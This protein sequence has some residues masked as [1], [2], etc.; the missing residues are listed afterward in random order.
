MFVCHFKLYIKVKS[1]VLFCFFSQ[2]LLNFLITRISIL[3][4][5][6]RMKG[7]PTNMYQW[8][9]K[10]VK[11]L[12]QMWMS[13][14]RTSGKYRST[15]HTTFF[16]ILLKRFYKNSH[17]SLS[18]LWWVFYQKLQQKTTITI[19]H[20]KNTNMYWRAAHLYRLL[21][22]TYLQDRQSDWISRFISW[23]IKVH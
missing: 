9:S 18:L 1:I 23:V 4:T 11:K 7:A 17:V 6:G 12:G 2:Y 20:G 8:L 16:S 5:M 10:S 13:F 14:E 15:E 22:I 19:V 3:L 21:I